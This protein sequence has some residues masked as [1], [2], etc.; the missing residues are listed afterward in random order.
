MQ[1]YASLSEKYPSPTCHDYHFDI[2]KLPPIQNPFASDYQMSTERQPLSS[3]R[4]SSVHKSVN[5]TKPVYDGQA[6]FLRQQLQV[7]QIVINNLNHQQFFKDGELRLGFYSL[8]GVQSLHYAFTF[9][10][11][12][13][14]KSVKEQIADLG[15]QSPPQPE[16]N[17][18]SIYVTKNSLFNNI[19]KLIDTELG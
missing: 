16:D 5:S 7:Y 9:G 4:S 3:H 19:G 11:D 15:M 14:K 18:P 10:Q 17:Y 12:P 1:I 13:S 6:L 2:T 8:S